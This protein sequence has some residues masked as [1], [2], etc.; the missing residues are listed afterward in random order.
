MI[1]RNQAPAASKDKAGGSSKP[2]KPKK[3]DGKDDDDKWLVY[4]KLER[5]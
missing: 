4:G 3:K 2:R 5:E 1:P